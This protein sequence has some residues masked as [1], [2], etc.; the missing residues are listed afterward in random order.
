SLS[1]PVLQVYL[2]SF[3]ASY[4]IY[5][6]QTREVTEL[7]GEGLQGSVLQYAAWGASGNQLVYILENNI[8]YQQTAHSPARALTS[9]G[10]DGVIFN[11]IADW[12]YEGKDSRRREE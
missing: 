12:V 7:R 2:Y 4:A 3:T 5:N 11:G 6:I 8:Y 9:S 1:C 10:K